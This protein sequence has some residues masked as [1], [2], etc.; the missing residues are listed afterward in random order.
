MGPNKAILCGVVLAAFSL[1]IIGCR[2]EREDDGSAHTHATS[3]P[4]EG[5]AARKRTHDEECIAV[6][7]EYFDAVNKQDIRRALAVTVGRAARL[8]PRA[9]ANSRI[10]GQP[11]A[12]PVEA[13]LRA[14]HGRSRTYDVDIQPADGSTTLN[15]V[16]TLIPVEGQWKIAAVMTLELWESGTDPVDLKDVSRPDVEEATWSYRWC[17]EEAEYLDAM[18]AKSSEVLGKKDDDALRMPYVAQLRCFD[19]ALCG[20]TVSSD[21][22]GYVFEGL[23][24][25]HYLK[26]PVEVIAFLADG[27]PGVS[28]D[29]LVWTIKLKTGIKYSRNPCFGLDERGNPRT[30]T[31]TAH[32]F[33]LAFKRI[34]DHHMDSPPAEAFVRDRIVGMDEFRKKTVRYAPGDFS[35][36]DKE[37]LDGVVALDE[38]TLQIK[39]K[40]PAP[41]FLHVLTM[42]PYAPIPREVI[43]H[44]LATAESVTGRKPVPIEKRKAVLQGI[45]SMVGTGP[46]ILEKHVPKRLILFVR[47]PDFR[48]QH[49]PSQGR[50]GDREAGLLDDAAYRKKQ[51]LKAP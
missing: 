16:A 51:N 25:Y 20:D 23:Y 40:Q 29:G 12:V 36:Y 26:R 2:P 5:G 19:P 48:D 50:Y 27:M 6:I 4:T 39:L 18:T 13:G 46:Y 42:T 38:H 34:A 33:V 3:M 17:I 24:G 44:Y 41:Q 43:T 30:R 11:V 1:A 10:T 15:A 22:H 47:N 28:P 8:A 31:V 45:A 32:D 21:F 9:C 7:N 14:E 49:Y 35:R 37:E